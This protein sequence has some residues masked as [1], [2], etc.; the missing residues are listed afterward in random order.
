MYW[1]YY[2]L[3]S[4]MKVSLFDHST[5]FNNGNIMRINALDD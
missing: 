4:A 3:L 5:I 2:L 1:I